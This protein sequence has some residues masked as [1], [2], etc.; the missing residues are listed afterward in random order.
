MNA[1]MS[2]VNSLKISFEYFNVPLKDEE[3]NKVVDTLINKKKLEALEL[4]CTSLGQWLPKMNTLEKELPPNLPNPHL[5]E[6]DPT[7]SLP[8]P[9]NF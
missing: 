3:C 8:K 2:Y 1:H 6:T 7:L 5:T 4:K 9:S